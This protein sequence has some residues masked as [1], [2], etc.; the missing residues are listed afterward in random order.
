MF[1]WF[2]N[3]LYMISKTI[4]R[5]IDGLILCANKLCGI[6]AISFD[7]EETD[8][9]SYLLFSNEI[10][11]AF[12]VSAILA[13]ILLVVFTVFMIIRTIAKDK[14]EG[15]PAQIAI[16]A[17]KTLVMFF[18]VP[19]VMIAFMTIGN[20]F[21][22]ALY[23]A[24]VQS[25]A[26]PGAF[27]FSAF[28]QDGGME[29]E[30]A[31]LFRTGEWD[32]NNTDLVSAHMTLSD[33]PFFFSWL[34]GGVVLFGVGTAMLTFV[35]RVLSIVILYIAAPISI[36][37]SVLDDGARF[38][39]WRDQFLSKFIM[40]YG[41]ILAI[42]I[43]A[44]V[45][46]LVTKPGFAFF[47][48]EGSAFLDLIMKLLIIGGGALTMQKSM[49]LVGNLVSQGAGSNELRDN[50]FSMGSLARM[51]KGA[52]GKALGIAGS[53]ARNTVGLPFRAGKSIVGDA[54]NQQSRH[55][56]ARLLRGLGLDGGLPRNNKTDKDGNPEPGSRDSGST[57]NEKTNYGSNPNSTKDAINNKDFKRSFG[58]DNTNNNNNN[59]NNSVDDAI[60]NGDKKKSTQNNQDNQQPKGGEN[61]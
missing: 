29:E 22:T 33:F 54:I 19:A 1:D 18:L 24:T 41:M 56:G 15:T 7:G 58:G 31:E 44:M 30:M 23:R 47:P 27:L 45:C 13:T 53:V 35:D 59:K 2:W 10:G 50:A 4:F 3:F 32:Y 17:F 9:L 60:N 39:L 34:A 21:V 43:Y 20:A 48:E 55:L 51:A 40:G 26:S 36:S 49:A 37:T 28:A 25:A 61:K 52:A 8:F 5:L 46:G 38:K 6:D 42:N 12:R 14:A 57:N 11:F 16:K